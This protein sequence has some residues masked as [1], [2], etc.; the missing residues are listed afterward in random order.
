MNY[1]TGTDF[2]PKLDEH[3][4]G[5]SHP[6][7][8][9]IHTED[10]DEPDGP[11]TF[12]LPKYAPL[13]SQ[14]QKAVGNSFGLEDIIEVDEHP[15]LWTHPEEEYS[16]HLQR[17]PN[18]HSYFYSRAHSNHERT[19]TMRSPSLPMF[20]PHTSSTHPRRRDRKHSP[21]WFGSSVQPLLTS[22]S[23]PLLRRVRLANSQALWLALYFAFNLLLTLSN[24]SVLI[25]FPFPY[26]MTA[27][28]ALCSTFGGF[29]LRWRGYY[30]SKPLKFR[31][32]MVLAAFSV[33]YA[34]NIAVSNVSLNMVTVPFH[35][36]VRA[37]TPVFTIILS[38]V[39]LDARTAR[40][41]VTSLAP[42][43]LG[44]AFA[45]YGDYYFTTWGLCL[46]LLG[47]VLAALKTIYTNILQSS[48]HITPASPILLKS[49]PTLFALRRYL[50]PP[51]LGL[52]P[53]DLLMRMSPLA[54]IQCV[55]YAQVTGELDRLRHFGRPYGFDGLASVSHESYMNS[56]QTSSNY[57][58]QALDYPGP[59]I[60]GLSWSH[61][62]VLLVNGGVAF[63]L[64]VV[65]F[66]ANGKNKG[67]MLCVY[68]ER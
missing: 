63:G 8:I 22:L 49:I 25:D 18:Q 24:K 32:E 41:K 54:F 65:S 9:L 15:M 45:T 5:L 38:A 4:F 67:L 40:M 35:Q 7:E 28:H 6:Q 52:H 27:L 56:T 39:L 62:L 14:P 17:S 23:S 66:T 60:G 10:S 51:T 64:N 42:L 19:S 2:L 3:A 20:C 31:Q 13:S 61:I 58:A 12:L 26:T 55:I 37:V 53:L 68:S 33:L 34:V 11:E 59:L 57:L 1:F 36:V 30:T 44:V 46:T 16:S 47:T 43:I 21:S 50:I 29:T 48:T